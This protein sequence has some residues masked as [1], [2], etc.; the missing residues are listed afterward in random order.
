MTFSGSY[1]VSAD[2]TAPGTRKHWIRRMTQRVYLATG[3]S[4]YFEQMTDSSVVDRTIAAEVQGDPYLETLID[5]LESVATGRDQVLDEIGERAEE[6]YTR[7]LGPVQRERE[8]RVD[9]DRADGTGER[10]GR[11]R[12]CG[13]CWPADCCGAIRSFA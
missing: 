2:T 9:A 3:F 10:Q 1:T 7:A 8:A 11:R 5:G 6:Y 12:T 4:S 13:A